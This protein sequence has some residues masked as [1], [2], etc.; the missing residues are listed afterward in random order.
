MRTKKVATVIDVARAANCSSHTVRTLADR[1]L[2][3][4]TRDYNKW[5]RFPDLKKSVSQAKQI[6]QEGH[7][8]MWPDG[9]NQEEASLRNGS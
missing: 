5:R 4:C 8:Q 6:L 2:I 9:N 7:T 3:D 1:N